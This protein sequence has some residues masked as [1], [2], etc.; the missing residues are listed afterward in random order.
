MRARPITWMSVLVLGL[1]VWS[2]RASAD[3]PEGKKET[4]ATKYPNAVTTPPRGYE[5]EKE[6][7]AYMAF[8][9]A[10]RAAGFT[11]IK[12]RAREQVTEGPCEPHGQHVNLDGTHGKTGDWVHVGSITSCKICEE[13]SRGPELRR[14]VWRIHPKF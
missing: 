4:C 7:D 8:R 12:K 5:Y 3:K 6:Q 14:E 10:A 2:G 13:T 9:R 1:L 11:E